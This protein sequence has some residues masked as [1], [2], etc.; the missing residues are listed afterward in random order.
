M[1]CYPSYGADYCAGKIGLKSKQVAGKA[2]KLGLKLNKDG[3]HY[4]RSNQPHRPKPSNRLNVHP[5]QF[6]EP[7]TPQTCYLLG[8]LWADGNL[9]AHY[10]I[11]LEVV[12]EDAF[13]FKSVFETTGKW[14]KFERQRKHWKPLTKFTC[15]SKVLFE[16][17]LSMGF[18]DKGCSPCEL[19]SSLPEGL[20][21]YWYRGFLD[22][23]GN[24]YFNA[25]Q[26][27][28][29]LTFSSCY[30]QDWTFMKSLFNELEM[31]KWKCR[32]VKSKHSYSIARCANKKDIVKFGEY[33]YQG[34][35]FGL[36][37]KKEKFMEIVS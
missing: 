5:Q 20:R 32:K 37:R 31:Q 33:I 17:L 35:E 22:G 16:H 29:Q 2:R 24:F 1:E 7:K 3:W 6:I 19:I 27:L 9:G 23:D 8:L 18:K 14:N 10:T 28:R 15:A 25:K 36:S 30:E 4:V 21:H 12:S 26:Y 13:Y 34:E 11:N